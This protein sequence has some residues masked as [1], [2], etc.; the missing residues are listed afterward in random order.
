MNKTICAAA[1][2][3]AIANAVLVCL[4]LAKPG[5]F[6]GFSGVLNVCTQIEMKHSKRANGETLHFTTQ[7]MT[8]ERGRVVSCGDEK[9]FTEWDETAAEKA[10][11]LGL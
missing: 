10:K 11:R 8:F 4:L 5:N 6:D 9:T 7:R 2:A 1:I 3:L